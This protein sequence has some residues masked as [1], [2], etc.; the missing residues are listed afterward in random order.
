MNRNKG[1]EKKHLRHSRFLKYF[2]WIAVFSLM[3]PS[4]YT[5]H[6]TSLKNVSIFVTSERT[7]EEKNMLAKATDAIT[8][9]SQVTGPRFSMG[10]KLFS[11]SLI[12]SHVVILLVSLSMLGYLDSLPIVKQ[13]LIFYLYK[14]FTFSLIT[15]NCSW[16]LL[17]VLHF[18]SFNGYEMNDLVIK[19]M[20]FLVYFMTVQHLVFLNI[21]TILNLYTRKKAMIDPPMPWGDND[22]LGLKIIR[23]S[24]V[25]SIFVFTA[26]L[27]MNGMYP[28]LY[29]FFKNGYNTSLADLP[30]ETAIF[31]VPILFLIITFLITSLVAI[32]YKYTRQQNLDTG[33][34]QHHYILDLLGVVLIIARLFFSAF[35][36]SSI[37]NL[38]TINSLASIFMQL[39][40]I[41]KNDE[42]T[43]YVKSYLSFDILHLNIRFVCMCLCIYVFVGLCV[44]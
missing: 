24:T 18:T 16:V 37:W 15:L 26:T 32:H 11:L 5:G 42:L 23:L 7:N 21:I 20:G 34:P 6:C 41:L 14:D 29:F 17:R 43:S 28:I 19:M 36:L 35:G 9:T 2:A 38:L 27:Y 1:V 13:T 39:V 40:I 3:V 44:N 12:L 31:L 4:K 22:D 30:K 25:V 8:S 33:I 10:K